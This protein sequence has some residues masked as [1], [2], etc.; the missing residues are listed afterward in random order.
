MVC[1][2][3]FVKV[4]QNS[5]QNICLGVSLLIKLQAQYLQLHQKE[6]PAQVFSSEFCEIFKNT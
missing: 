1:N 5:L 2:I 6:T 4:L 3:D